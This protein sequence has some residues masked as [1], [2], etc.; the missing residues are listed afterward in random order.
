MEL[1]F[2]DPKHERLVNDPAALSKKYDKKGQ[3]NADDILGTIDVLYAADTLLDVPRGFRPH[4]LHGGYQG[5]FAVDVTD[6][7]RC[8]F[9]PNELNNPEFRIDNYKSITRIIIVEIFKDYH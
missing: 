4:P 7:H 6:T 1:E 9:R 2:D 8:I 5:Y 3:N